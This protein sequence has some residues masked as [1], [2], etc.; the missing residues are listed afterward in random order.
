MV[1]TAGYSNT[2][3]GHFPA[4][5]RKIG[6]KPQFNRRDHFGAFKVKKSP[7]KGR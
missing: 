4:L 3:T 2:P 7:I 1:R 6:G 5:T